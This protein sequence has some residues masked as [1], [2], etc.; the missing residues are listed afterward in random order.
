[1]RAVVASLFDL[2]LEAVPHFILLPEWIWQNV[3]TCFFWSMGYECCGSGYPGKQELRFE[4]SVDGYF[5]A[6]V[7]SKNFDG[8]NHA[9]VM[10][11]NGVVVHDPSPTK[12]YQGENIRETGALLY[13]QMVEKRTDNGWTSW[14]KHKPQQPAA[15]A[16]TAS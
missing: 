13:W 8:K 7:P 6:T 3:W 2:E 16:A 14:E 9:V 11:M 1:M 12:K 5:D 4:D 15:G 10:D